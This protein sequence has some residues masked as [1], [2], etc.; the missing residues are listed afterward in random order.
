MSLSS[1]CSCATDLLLYSGGTTE[2]Y[3]EEGAL[4]DC[5]AGG[6]GISAESIL[7]ERGET[8]RSLSDYS[9]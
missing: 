8:D 4:Y 7:L 1:C 5:G 9:S 3:I 6:I 2:V